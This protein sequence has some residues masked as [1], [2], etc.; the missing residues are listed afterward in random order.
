MSVKIETEDGSQ[1]SFHGRRGDETQEKRG[2]NKKKQKWETLLW[3]R[4]YIVRFLAVTLDLND[5]N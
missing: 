3:N 4:S 5:L 2:E 1:L